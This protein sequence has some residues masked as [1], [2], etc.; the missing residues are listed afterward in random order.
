MRWLNAFCGDTGSGVRPIEPK[1]N[2]ACQPISADICASIAK[3]KR[4]LMGTEVAGEGFRL[5]Q[6]PK[7]CN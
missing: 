1:Y 4:N 6:D 2:H 3:L 5:E 7:S